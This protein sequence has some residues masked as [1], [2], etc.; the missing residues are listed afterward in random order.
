MSKN[1][2]RKMIWRIDN[3]IYHHMCVCVCVSECIGDRF[4]M[5]LL[6]FIQASFLWIFHRNNV[7]KRVL[8]PSLNNWNEICCI[9]L[10]SHFD[11]WTANAS[12][13][14]SVRIISPLSLLFLFFFFMEA[15][16]KRN[17]VKGIVFYWVIWL[18]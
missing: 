17:R 5:F 6:Y 9:K 16:D 12:V 2:L 13:N 11:V 4:A 18:K 8:K 7:A 15:S 1:L 3:R 10:Q 14:K